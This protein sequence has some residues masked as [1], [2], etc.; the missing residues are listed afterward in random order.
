MPNGLGDS[1]FPTLLSLGW[2][3]LPIAELR[4]LCVDKFPLSDTRERIM[5]GLEEIVKRLRA[6][7]IVGVL[8]VNGSF[9]TEK[10][11]PADVDV[12]LFING[13]FLESATT[14]QVGAIDWVSSNLKDSFRCDSYVSIEYPQSHPQHSYGEYWRAYWTRQWGFDRE[15]NPVKGIAVVSL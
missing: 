8:W 6:K 14:E 7:D 13:T 15:D 9:L 3:H 4:K 11:N 10:I 2:H 1:G 12:V 5:Q